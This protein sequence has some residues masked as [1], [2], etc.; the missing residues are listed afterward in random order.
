MIA[1][2]NVDV[3]KSCYSFNLPLEAMRVMAGS[4]K[5][6]GRYVNKRSGFF[7]DK[8]HVLLTK[9]IFPWIEMAKMTLWKKILLLNIFLHY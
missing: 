4:D 9:L 2:L 8:E 7:G 1:Y 3:R 5:Y 6:K